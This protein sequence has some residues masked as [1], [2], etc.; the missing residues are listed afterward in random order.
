MRRESKRKEDKQEEN[1]NNVGKPTTLFSVFVCML[2]IMTTGQKP[3]VVFP[4]LYF[5]YSI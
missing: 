5:Y 2:R 4:P 3:H 1:R